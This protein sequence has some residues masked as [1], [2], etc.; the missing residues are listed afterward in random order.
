MLHS[1]SN[2][3]NEKISNSMD[4]KSEKKSTRSLKEALM[5][6]ND[7]GGYSSYETKEQKS[8]MLHNIS[9]I[10]C[11]HVTDDE[12]DDIIMNFGVLDEQEESCIEELNFDKVSPITNRHV[13]SDDWSS[14]LETPT[15]DHCSNLF[16]ELVTTKPEENTAA[17]DK[18]HQNI[19]PKDAEAISEVQTDVPSLMNRIAE[20]EVQLKDISKERDLWREKFLELKQQ[21]VKNIKL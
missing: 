16:K 9:L 2:K 15:K 17:I 10:P 5:M 20:L 6:I 21:N 4:T 12:D 19:K 11:E 13:F 7:M 18:E 1:Q 14:I 3:E 8:L